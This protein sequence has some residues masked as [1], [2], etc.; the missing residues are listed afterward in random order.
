MKIGDRVA[1]K[2]APEIEGR[3]IARDGNRLKVYWR[4]H[5][6]QWID[7]KALIRAGKRS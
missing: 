5:T 3:I 2:N 7:H 1:R 6:S 4:S